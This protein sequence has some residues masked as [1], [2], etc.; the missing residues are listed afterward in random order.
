MIKNV[1]NDIRFHTFSFDII[2]HIFSNVSVID[3]EQVN[4]C[5]EW[6]YPEFAILF[7]LAMFRLK[8]QFVEVFKVVRSIFWFTL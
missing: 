8:R 7:K 3:F 2:F 1:V 5:Q 6:Y 4:V